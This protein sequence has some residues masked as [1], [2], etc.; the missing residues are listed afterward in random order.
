VQIQNV[1][2]VCFSESREMLQFKFISVKIP[3]VA[4]E[5]H[6]VATSQPDLLSLFTNLY[7][8]ISNV[9]GFTYASSARLRLAQHCSQFDR[10]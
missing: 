6:M 1:D 4:K 2:S 5:I 8:L 9:P 10:I 3:T 7:L